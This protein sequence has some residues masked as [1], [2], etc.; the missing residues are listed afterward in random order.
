MHEIER[1]WGCEL[2]FVR[3]DMEKDSANPRIIWYNK[4]NKRA[5]G[6]R[7]L[8]EGVIKFIKRFGKHHKYKCI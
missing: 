8:R 3:F 1:K 5:N 4:K 6:Y 2:S 7:T